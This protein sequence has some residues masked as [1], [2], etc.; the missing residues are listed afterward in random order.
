[1]PSWLTWLSLLA[2]A[3]AAFLIF[4]LVLFFMAE[5]PK[6]MTG[7]GSYPDQ[8]GTILFDVLDGWEVQY[9][10]GGSTRVIAVDD[11]LPSYQVEIRSGAELGLN[12]NW[13]CTTLREVAPRVAQLAVRGDVTIRYVTVPC[14]ESD[15]AQQAFA[16]VDMIQ[17]DGTGRNA[18][19]YFA[20][21]D[22]Q[23]WVVVRSDPYAM[24]TPLALVEALQHSTT[25][26][27]LN[28]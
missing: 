9:G 28:S 21:I 14:A 1:M 2:V 13:D 20:P 10:E 4:L 5:D 24:E 25:T 6:L 15:S 27:R 16:R 22:G 12:L 23:R 17:G 19:L 7:P 3:L 18:L 8:S 11:S 26:T